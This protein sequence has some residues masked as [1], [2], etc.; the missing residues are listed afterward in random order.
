VIW[1]TPLGAPPDDFL[2]SSPLVYNGSIYEWVASFP[3]CPL[4]R[5]GIGDPG[6]HGQQPPQDSRGRGPAD[7]PGGDT[8]AARP[9]TTGGDRAC[10]LG[11]ASITARQTGF[12]RPAGRP[13]LPVDHR[14]G[15]RYPDMK[16][17][18]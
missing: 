14:V 18:T 4:V 3:D 6:Q 15:G 13:C 8:G 10:H 2:W 5:G 16:G 1:Q 9:V 11:T 7:S 12:A 17:R